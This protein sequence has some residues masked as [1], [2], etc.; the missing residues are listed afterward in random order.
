MAPDAGTA[1]A[2]TAEP[3]AVYRALRQRGLLQPDPAQQLAIERLQSL[4]RALLHYRPETGLRG[5]LARF[6]LA[7]NGGSHPPVGLYLCGPVGRGQSKVVEL[8][9]PFGAG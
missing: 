8:V 9:F 3:M 7:E 2:P 1:A 4:Y 5:W 6:G